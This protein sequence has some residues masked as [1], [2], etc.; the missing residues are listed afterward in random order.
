MRGVAPRASQSTTR[1]STY[2]SDRPTIGAANRVNTILNSPPSWMTRQPAPT[3]AAPISPP[4]SA[5]DELLGMLSAQVSRLHRQAVAT[6]TMIT[7]RL[8]VPGAI[9]SLPMV[10]ATATPKINGPENSAAAVTASATAGG[11]A[12]DEIIVA[13]ILLASRKPLSKLKKSARPMSS[14][15]GGVT[16]GSGHLD[17]DVADDV[18]GLVA[19]V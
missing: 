9:R 14:S 5:C 7:S 3:A 15:S 12:R 18:G 16:G 6:A 4:T 8:M 1:V 10:L 2:P 13:T 11:N 17:D 19:P